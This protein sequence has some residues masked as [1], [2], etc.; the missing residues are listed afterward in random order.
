M[1]E[2][3]FQALMTT[4]Q[5]FGEGSD[6][7]TI[8]SLFLVYPFSFKG[9]LVQYIG[10]V[11]RSEITPT[12]Y[13]YRD[14]KIDYLN[15]LFL[16]R[17]VYYR[18]ITTQATLF[19]GPEEPLVE[20]NQIRKIEKTIKVPIMDLEFHYGNAAFNYTD[21][22]LKITF[23][24]EIENSEIRPEFEVLKPYFIKALKSKIISVELFAELENGNIISQLATSKEIEYINKEIVENVKF[25]FLNRDVIG[26]VP[27]F[28]QNLLTSDEIQD[29]QNIFT[30]S[31]EI[32]AQILQKILKVVFRQ[33]F[34]FLFYWTQCFYLT[35]Q[36]F[37]S[38]V[39]DN[40]KK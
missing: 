32:L 19:D 2:G 15:K 27:K 37:V 36:F 30:N 1:Q 6:L 31:E 18:K 8:N 35:L 28:K 38:D 39:Q 16:K 26:K 24:L 25:Q 21:N 12:I 14:I 11:Q 3:N 7:D 5:Y 20:K 4:G 17:N 23:E 40:H 9:K 34:L 22:E 29:H 33:E 10:R 13:D